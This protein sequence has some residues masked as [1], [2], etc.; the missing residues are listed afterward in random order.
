MLRSVALVRTDVLEEPSAS[1]I[2]VTRIGELGTALAAT[3][4]RR[5]QRRRYSQQHDVTSQKTPFFIVTAVKT[6]NLTLKHIDWWTS[7]SCFHFMYFRHR[8]RE[9]TKG[10]LWSEAVLSAVLWCV[11]RLRKI[12]AS[13]GDRSG[14]DE[15]KCRKVSQIAEETRQV[16]A[17]FALTDP[18]KLGAPSMGVYAQ[19]LVGSASRGS[20]PDIPLTES[21]LRSSRR[22]EEWRL[23]LERRWRA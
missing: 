12:L 16:D 21:L 1:F 15:W 4:N 5:T 14:S 10:A 20:D 23:V 18:T 8:F 11:Q 13:K 7:P 6:S 2:R 9:V 3:S 19:F 22:T 17:I